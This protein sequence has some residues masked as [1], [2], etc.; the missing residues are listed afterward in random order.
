V[1]RAHR[2]GQ[3]RQ[4][5][6]YRFVTEDTIEEKIIEKAAIKLKRDHLIIKEDKIANRKNESEAK[7]SG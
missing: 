7:L 6:I 2:I 5:V 1:D 4:V 3:K